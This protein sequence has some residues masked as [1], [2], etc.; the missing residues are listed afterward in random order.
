MFSSLHEN[1]LTG[2]PQYNKAAFN[3]QGDRVPEDEWQKVNVEGR[4]VVKMVVF[5]GWSVGFRPL[6]DEA[7]EKKWEHAVMLK[8]SGKYVGRLGYNTLENVASI[9]SAL[10]EYDYITK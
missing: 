9:N 3:G 1:A 6:S 8:E 5:E 2:I 7:L 4:N 10:R